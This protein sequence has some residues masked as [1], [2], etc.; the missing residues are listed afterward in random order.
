MSKSI[1]RLAS[2][3]RWHLMSDR[4]RYARL[5]ARSRAHWDTI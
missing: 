3:I 1:T 2:Q 4:E 5:W